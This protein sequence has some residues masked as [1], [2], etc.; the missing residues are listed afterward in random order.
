VVAVLLSWALYAWVEAP[1]TRRFSTS[2]KAKAARAAAA[3][4]AAT[5]P[6]SATADPAKLAEKV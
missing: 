5:T 1:L 6:A 4:T 3:A 2:R